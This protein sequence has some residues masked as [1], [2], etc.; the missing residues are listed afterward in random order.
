[1]DRVVIALALAFL[2][3]AFAADVYFNDFNGPRGTVYPEWTS[4][5]YTNTANTAGTVA[6][7]SGPQAVTNVDSP[8]GKQRFLGE[9]GGPVII[10]APPYDPQ[11]F[12]RVDETVTLTLTQLK[13]HS[14]VTLGF[15]LYVLKSWDGNNPNYGPDRW[16]L[17]VEGGAT[18]LDTTFSNNFKTDA[19]N[20]SLQNYPAPNSLPQTS[21]MAVNSLGYTFFGD[22][23]YR[24]TFTFPHTSDTL[25]L[26]FSSSLFE[27]KGT[28]DESWGLDN[29]R[30][31]TNQDT[32]VAVSAIAPELG[33]APESLG[34]IYGVNLAAVT[35][36]AGGLPLPTH[37]GSVSVAVIDAVSVSRF[38]PLL[39]VSPSQI[40]FEVPAGTQIGRAAFAV[41]TDAGA[42]Q[43]GM[44][45]IQRIAPGLF[46][47][48]GDGRGVVAATAVR[49]VIGSNLLG[50]AE[51][52]RCG[53]TPGSCASVP[54]DV[55]IDAPVY[56]SLYG[57][58]IRGAPA[59]DVSVSIG[60]RPVPVL[61]AGP[62]PV[63]EGLDQVNVS[64]PLSLRG[65]G[66]VDLVLSVDGQSSNTARI[67]IQ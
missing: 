46:T 29:V 52:F 48:N 12:V 43:N 63:F 10:A 5:G 25:V 58:G 20:L 36:T 16:S 50:T 24:L 51:V 13:P 67:N 61:Y 62:Q 18:L 40:N 38:A 64:L 57:T 49:V 34:S 8:N 39:Y 23:T 44:A 26:R 17:R 22:S 45:N 66:E 9:F 35:Q 4:T 53:S 32:L 59:G 11:H 54:I 55:G 65:L 41:Q 2:P 14:M 15:D 3:G 47:A 21:A 1:M 7:G 30:V 28:D 37:L 19:N 42:T 6:N 33:L 60:N 31:S 56:V 27:G